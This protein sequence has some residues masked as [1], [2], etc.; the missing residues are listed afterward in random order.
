LGLSGQGKDVVS[1]ACSQPLSENPALFR[2][3]FRGD[4]N[5]A[6]QERALRVIVMKTA[7]EKTLY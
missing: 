5:G 4:T 7:T 6:T 3:I 1:H 2:G